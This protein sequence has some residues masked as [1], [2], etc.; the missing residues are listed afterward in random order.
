MKYPIFWNNKKYFIHLFTVFLLEVS[1]LNFF[2][3]KLTFYPTPISCQDYCVTAKLISGAEEGKRWRKIKT[4]QL[5]LSELLSVSLSQSKSGNSNKTFQPRFKFCEK[6]I[7]KEFDQ[8]H[9]RSPLLCRDY[10][11]FVWFYRRYCAVK[12]TRS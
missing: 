8:T 2:C 3:Q 7:N 10:I 5:E 6:L 12:I 9:T 4:F 11:F 1:D